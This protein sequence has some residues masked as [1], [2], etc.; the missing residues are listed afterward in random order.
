MVVVGVNPRRS[1]FEIL[2]HKQSPA[3]AKSGPAGMWLACQFWRCSQMVKPQ[4]LHNDFSKCLKASHIPAGP[5][6]AP[7]GLC[8][9]AAVQSK[10]KIRW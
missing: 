5:D 9:C 1:F 4:G 7:A 10:E 8:L 2:A 6:F 3:G